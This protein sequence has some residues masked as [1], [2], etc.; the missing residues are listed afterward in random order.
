MTTS[1]KCTANIEEKNR[2]I[3]RK[4][5]GFVRPILRKR[6]G[7]VRPILRKRIGFVR[8]ILR[9]RIGFYTVNIEEKSKNADEK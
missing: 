6:I 1:V 3:L 5:I 2:P 8:P 9:K 7:F 4:R